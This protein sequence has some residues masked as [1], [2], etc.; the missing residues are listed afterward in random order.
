VAFVFSVVSTGGTEAEAKTRPDIVPPVKVRVLEAAALEDTLQLTGGVQPWLDLILS[1]E[2]NGPV[3][4]LSVDEGDRVAKGDELARIDTAMLQARQAQAQAQ[5]KLAEQELKRV[6]RLGQ[7]GVTT[8]RD[9][10]NAI[11]SRDVASAAARTLDIQLK[12]SVLTAPVEGIVERVFVDENEFTDTGKPLVRIVQTD[13]VKVSVGVPERDVLAF[14]EGA[15]VTVTIDALPE[16]EF[17][18]C[19]HYIATVADPMTRTFTAEIEVDNSK[20]LIKPGMIARASLV[21]R[22][23][24]D[25][26][27]VPI[28]ATVLLDQQR[29]VLVEEDGVAKLK[30]I[31]TGV[32][33]GNVV[34]ITEGLEPGDRL[35]VVGQRDARPDAQVHVTEVLE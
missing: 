16:H 13:K 25:A 30:A 20:G 5:L 10:D 34:Q 12:K 6:S 19:I 15:P 1:A 17:Q 9:S 21:R 31:E 2:G 11:A 23:Y 28:F 14:E 8:Q 24:E 22:V 26:I 27:V 35:I 33:Q 3:E 29:Y 4:S 32:I 7:S 18:G